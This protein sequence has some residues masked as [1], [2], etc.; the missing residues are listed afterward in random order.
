MQEGKGSSFKVGLLFFVGLVILG[1][2]TV[3]I[4]NLDWIFGGTSILKVAFLEVSGLKEGDPVRISGVEMG[5]VEK[6][7]LVQGGVLC[8]LR[9]TEK[10]ELRE[11]A[12]FTVAQTTMVGGRHIAIFPGTPGKPRLD[13]SQVHKGTT[14]DTG[15]D[16]IGKIVNENR[17]SV[18]EFIANLK[19]ISES[20]KG[21][22][23]TM[24]KL[25]T[26]DGLYNEAKSTLEEIRAAVGELKGAGELIRKVNDQFDSGEGTLVKLLK[27]NEMYDKLAAAAD[28]LKA[29]VEDVRAGNGTLGRLIKDP[30]LYDDART[31]I[32]D[33]KEAMGTIKEAVASVRRIT[34][35]VEAG[36][37]TVGRLLNDK[38][39]ADELAAT[40]TDVKA[41]AASLKNIVAKV[42]RGEGTI[43]KL[44]NEEK[45]YEQATASLEA[46]DKTLGQASRTRAYVTL[47]TRYYG[48]TQMLA[49]HASLRIYPREDRYL[50][51]G[52]A[53][54]PAGRNS[55][56]DFPEKRKEDRGDTFY[57]PTVMLGWS[58]FDNRVDVAGGLLEGRFGGRVSGRLTIPY[59]DHD[60][61]IVG[62][63]RDAHDDPKKL[64]ERVG[65]L[66]ARAYLDT[67]IWRW[68]HV[69][70]GVSRI[71]HDAEFFAGATFTYEDE[72]IRTFISLIGLAK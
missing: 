27:S 66:M 47:G 39:M 14:L 34:E 53:I 12:V 2:A 24:G 72:D 17:K 58:F 28:D 32:A 18:Q 55:R 67:K 5:R 59:L 37:G 70:A 25:L 52:V 31:L 13:G 16:A 69:Q 48:E 64:D 60:V 22:K 46:L 6:L 4:G 43:G 36:E 65:S 30:A 44:V 40:V 10:Y 61:S 19:D 50:E 35:K 7:E 9:M 63:I 71:G 3:T 54:W 11:D 8:V 51:A 57:Q 1:A 33:M 29:M 42:E 62:E 38:A 15:L 23:G 26:D 20:L 56:W 49:P 41:I 68:F 45:L 21:G